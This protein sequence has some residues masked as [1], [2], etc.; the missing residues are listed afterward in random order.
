MNEKPKKSGYAAL[1]QLA[2][3]PIKA[4]ISKLSADSN[5][6]KPRVRGPRDASR[7]AGPR[8]TEASVG[9]RAKPAPREEYA[10]EPNPPGIQMG[11]QRLT[12]DESASG[13]RIDNYLLRVLKGVP[14]SLVYRILRSGEVRINSGRAKPEQ[15]VH[16][17]DIVRVPPIRIGESV[18]KAPEQEKIDWLRTQILADERDMLV[19]NKPSGLAS[20][21][22]SGIS[23]GAIEAMRVL[24]PNDALE[25]AHRLDRDTSGLL[26]IARKRTALLKLQ[27]LMR[28]GEMR[29]TYLALG[30]GMPEKDRFDVRLSLK[31]FDLAGGE[32]IVKVDENGKPSLTY[33]KVLERFP[34]ANACLLEVMLGTGR[35]HQIRVHAQSA[36]LPLAGDEKYHQGVDHKALAK[37]GLKRLFLHAHALRWREEGVERTF[38]AELPPH[39]LAVLKALR[40]AG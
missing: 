29:K 24:F 1:K 4:P 37:F 27:N 35:T 5:A 39:L 3:A 28:A 38:K 10:I 11:V 25:L 12:I 18:A 2:K 30:L 31:K 26:L 34:A 21:G 6:P 8:T 16:S 17:G 23:F 9:L 40:E 13:Q 22:G 36:G 20:H 32:R 19:L 7:N 33:F 14:R 15:R